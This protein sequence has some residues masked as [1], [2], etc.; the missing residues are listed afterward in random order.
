MP[1]GVAVERSAR[2]QGFSPVLVLIVAVL[3]GGPSWR[4]VKAKRSAPRSCGCNLGPHVDV[5]VE[6]VVTHN[7]DGMRPTDENAPLCMGAAQE[8]ARY[9]PSGRH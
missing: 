9:P 6:L 1:C 7:P 8:V 4:A 3:L 2:L 5:R